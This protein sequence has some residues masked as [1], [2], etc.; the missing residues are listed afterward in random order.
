VIVWPDWFITYASASTAATVRIA[1]LSWSRVPPKTPTAR[2][3]RTP[4]TAIV[5]SP[6]ISIS[7]PAAGSQ[8]KLRSG[9]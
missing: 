6:E 1:H 9:W 7:V 4:I 5:T 2:R 3:G 8:L